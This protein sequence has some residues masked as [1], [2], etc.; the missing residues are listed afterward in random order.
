MPVGTQALSVEVRSLS[1]TYAGRSVLAN[2]EFS[3][4]PGTVL[5]IIGASG[6]GK[7]TLLRVISGIEP[8]DCGEIW[9]NG[10]NATNLPA[11]KRPVHTVF[12]NYGLFPHLTVY[13]NVAFPLRVAGVSRARRDEQVK[14]ALD[15]V[16]LGRFA[17]RNVTTLSGGERQ[18]V[19]LARALVDNPRC[20]LLDEPLSALDP[21]L[22]DR[23]IT[24]LQQLQQRLNATYIYVT[25]DREEAMRVADTIGVLHAGRLEQCDSPERLYRHPTSEFVASYMGDINWLNGTLI[26]DNRDQFVRLATGHLIP[27]PCSQISTNSRVRLGIRP[28]DIQLGSTG[29]LSA[30]VSARRFT[31]SKTSINLKLENGENIHSLLRSTD[32]SPNLGETV[33]ISWPPKLTHIFHGSDN[34]SD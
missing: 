4:T 9:I 8:P 5:A 25:H 1:K 27:S 16:D 6:S 21:H 33:H 7:S 20:V 15:W 10:T 13:H 26:E 17:S 19:A 18:R 3:V 32:P 29:F 22:R 14:R 23:T 11:N 12:Q 30:L 24:L 28:E 31:G 2:I 34:N